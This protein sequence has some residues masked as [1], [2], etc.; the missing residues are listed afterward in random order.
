MV[1]EQA[2]EQLELS[3][4][5]LP[6][7]YR[8]VFDL[9][10]LLKQGIQHVHIDGAVLRWIAEKLGINPLPA[11]ADCWNRIFKFHEIRRKS[12]PPGISIKTDGCMASITFDKQGAKYAFVIV[13]ILY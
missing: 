12:A 11:P 7:I 6:T 13:L 2:D 9:F 5:N 10:P 8:S 3:A 1:A 4:R